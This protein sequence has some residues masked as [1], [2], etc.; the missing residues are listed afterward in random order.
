MR[1]YCNNYRLRAG[2]PFTFRLLPLAFFLL[3]KPN[4]PMQ[5]NRV[6]DAAGFNNH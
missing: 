4:Q 3:T 5:F 1:S 6:V 2:L